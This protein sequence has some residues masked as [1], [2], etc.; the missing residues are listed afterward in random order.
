L[1]LALDKSGSMGGQKLEKAL[2][3][4]HMI[5]G[6]M[7]DGETISLV[8]FDSEVCTVLPPAK[9]ADLKG[10]DSILKCID[11]GSNTNLCGGYLEAARNALS[12]SIGSMSRIVLLSDGQANEGITINDSSVAYIH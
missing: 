8:T 2:E 12:S 10:I 3:A 6:M 11:A 5:A 1:A 4:T 9:G 7:A